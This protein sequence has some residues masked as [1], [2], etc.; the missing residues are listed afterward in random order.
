MVDIKDI[1]E[2][3]FSAGTQKSCYLASTKD[4]GL[5]GEVQVGVHRAHEARDC[6]GAWYPATVARDNGDGTYVVHFYDE[7]SRQQVVY[8]KL[9][10][11]EIRMARPRRCVIKK[12][13][14]SNPMD[15]SFWE[16]DM[17]AFEMAK[18]LVGIWNQL[19]R[20]DKGYI[21]AEP[22]VTEVVGDCRGKAGFARGEKVM[23]EDYFDG[24]MKFSS[25]NGWFADG[26]LGFSVH[27]FCHWTY[28]HTN[29]RM[30]MCDAQG[31]KV[32]V[33]TYHGKVVPGVLNT[34]EA[35]DAN[36]T[37]CSANVVSQNLDGTFEV[38]V[39]GAGAGPRR[40]S[41]VAE[42]RIRKR[43]AAYVLTDACLHSSTRSYGETD[44]GPEGM[45]NWFKYHVCNHH[46]DPS[47]I[48]PPALTRTSSL[49]STDTGGGSRQSCPSTP[50]GADEP[51]VAGAV[52][53][54]ANMQRLPYCAP[55]GQP[56]VAAWQPHPELW[57]QMTPR[58]QPMSPRQCQLWVP[59]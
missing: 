52:V 54:P 35:Q 11:D 44:L 38:D 30:L 37:W 45:Q 16:E 9:R 39:L 42:A 18:Y 10:K 13:L 24:F 48:R 7:C 25:N 33:G 43:T 1:S 8:P 47:W 3:P 59:Q 50:A 4:L 17:K 14:R 29:G 23:V 32:P 12:A 46:C 58:W 51:P 27:A 55:C 28:H 21:M 5:Y 20:V 31:S 41:Q 2:R 22:V 56:P 34:Y 15:A 53:S 36:G 26:S 49:A 57:P 40:C 19:G 6:R